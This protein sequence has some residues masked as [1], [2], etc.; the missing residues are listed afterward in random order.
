M[1]EKK[2]YQVDAMK[3]MMSQLNEQS[4]LSPSDTHCDALAYAMRYEISA[5][6]LEGAAYLTDEE[7]RKKYEAWKEVISGEQSESEPLEGSVLTRL[8]NTLAGDGKEPELWFVK[9]GGEC[10]MV[11]DNAIHAADYYSGIKDEMPDPFSDVAASVELLC[12][13]Y[14][15]VLIAEFINGSVVQSV[16]NMTAYEEYLLPLLAPRKK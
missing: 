15:S 13:A 8:C 7:A 3:Y 14:G 10:S 5:T 6:S 11:T 4:S 2:N 9:V 16:Q 1:A 12:R